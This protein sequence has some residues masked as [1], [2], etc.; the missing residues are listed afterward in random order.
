M[1]GLAI[2]VICLM[3]RLSQAAIYVVSST[4]DGGAGALR[5]QIAAANANPGADQI[6]FA[7]PGAGP[8][9][10]APL[11]ALPTITRRQG[12]RLPLG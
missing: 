8:H 6:I 11:S 2:G 4:A 1:L 9:S 7:I 5:D 12:H 3:G 10:I